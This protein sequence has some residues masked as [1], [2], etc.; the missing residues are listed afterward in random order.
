MKCFWSDCQ[1]AMPKSNIVILTDPASE[2]PVHR[3]RVTLHP[4]QGEY[5]RDK[6]MLQRIRFT[7]PQAFQEEIGGA[8]VLFLPCAIYN[9]TPPEGAG[10]FHG[11]PLDVKVIHFKGSRKRLLLKSW[12]FL[13]CSSSSDIV[14]PHLTT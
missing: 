3:N 8:S 2:L 13:Y 5:S 14:V 11:M 9:W 1:V 7:R 4:I 6:L 10:Q 12:K